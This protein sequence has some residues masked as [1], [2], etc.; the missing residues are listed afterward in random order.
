MAITLKFVGALRHASGAEKLKR[1]FA[2][3]SSIRDLINEIVREKP[4]LKRALM[5]N[6]S[7]EQITNAL[8]LVNGREISVLSGLETKIKDLDEVVF[9]PVIHGG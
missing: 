6:Q 5:D 8:V 3:D 1:D 2:E 9:V 7:K 4:E